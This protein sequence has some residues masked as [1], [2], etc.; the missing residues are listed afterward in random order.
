MIGFTLWSASSTILNP[1]GPGDVGSLDGCRD[2][3]RATW[4]EDCGR[5]TAVEAERRVDFEVQSPNGYVLAGWIVRR[6]DAP[7]AAA[8]LYVPGGGSDR[9]EASRY[10]PLADKLGFDLAVIDPVCQGL[11]PCPVPGLSYGARESMDVAAAV[12]ALERTYGKVERQISLPETADP[13]SIEAELRDG[14]LHLNFKKKPEA[15]P[16]KISVKIGG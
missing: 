11:S 6:S 15:Q 10:L 14:V 1:P 5:L 8:M 13:E 2:L 16:R 3:T 7:A 9:R 12:A 4:G